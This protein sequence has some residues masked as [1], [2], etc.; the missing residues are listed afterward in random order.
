MEFHVD[1]HVGR[2]AYIGSDE[3]RLRTI[4]AAAARAQPGDVI[5][6]H[7]GTYREHVVP[8]RGGSSDA[9]RITYRAAPGEQPV[10]TGSD[11]FTH[12]QY[13]DRHVWRIVIPNERFGSFN[14]YAEAVSGDWFDPGDRTHR[15]GMVFL[16]GRGIPESRSLAEVFADMSPGW[17]ATVSPNSTELVARFP[18]GTNPNSGSVEIAMRPTVFSPTEPGIDFLT[19]QG[20]TL[21]NAATDWVAPTSGQQGLITAYWSRG[22]IIEDCE[23]AWSKCVGI[24][25]G[26]VHDEWD[27]LR[28]STEGYYFSIIDAIG[29]GWSRDAI[30]GHVIRNNHVHDCGEAGIAGS[31]G[32]AFSV[33][34]ANDVHDCNALAGWTG[35]EMAG[36]K[37]HGAVDTVL[38]DNHVHDNPGCPGIWLDWMSQGTRVVGNLLHGNGWYDLHVEVSH[39]PTLV[40]NNIMLSETAVLFNSHGIAMAH[41]LVGGRVVVLDDARVTPVLEEHGTR[42]ARWEACPIG[43]AQWLNNVVCSADLSA[44]AS[45]D[46]GLPIR[47]DGNVFGEGVIDGSLDDRAVRDAPCALE[48]VD[49]GAGWHLSVSFERSWMEIHRTAVGPEALGAAHVAGQR[50]TAADGSGLAVGTDYFGR[51]RD[52]GQVFAG[53]FVSAGDSF[54]VW[55]KPP[56]PEEAV[57]REQTQSLIDNR[58]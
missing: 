9:E 48:L 54:R 34:E 31:M 45:T 56:Q 33:I 27:H 55:P 3:A 47:F 36:I 40:A 38:A 57:G 29:S 8:P 16:D 49:D 17:S 53:P 22:W 58:R 12:W 35:A 41:N 52:G 24:V 13:V 32:C 6:I 14:P 44:Y 37:F 46:A 51:P 23:I 20:L 30:G 11:V 10:V 19:V 18:A 4:S 43:D 7:A 50:F 26:K 28:G 1:A 15:R 25:L 39:G 5:T 21:V 2:D 42:I